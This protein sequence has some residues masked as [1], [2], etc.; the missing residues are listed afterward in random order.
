VKRVVHTDMGECIFSVLEF[1]IVVYV[2]GEGELHGECGNKEY[3]H[4][5]CK[6]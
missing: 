3:V 6:I 2:F 4:S 1:E 5:C